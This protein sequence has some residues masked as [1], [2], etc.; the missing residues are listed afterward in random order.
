MLRGRGNKIDSEKEQEKRMGHFNG[1]NV[2]MAI[3]HIDPEIEDIFPKR[4]LLKSEDL[5]LSYLRK[6]YKVKS[7][8]DGFL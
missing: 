6:E 8:S 4:K 3:I 7:I 5:G 1:W 2:A